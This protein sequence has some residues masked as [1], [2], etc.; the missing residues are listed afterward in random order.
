MARWRTGPLDRT[1]TPC[2]HLRRAKGDPRAR[3][4]DDRAALVAWRRAVNDAGPG[5]MIVRVGEHMA[6]GAPRSFQR[7]AVEL[8]GRDGVD[9][10][11]TAFD[12]AVWLLVEEGLLEH[13]TTLPMVFRRRARLEWRAA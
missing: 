13:T 11:G 8:L 5:P 3:A 10:F 4:R 6:D 12:E 2:A 1:T 7:L 9:A